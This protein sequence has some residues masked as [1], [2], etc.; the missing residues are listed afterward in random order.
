MIKNILLTA[1]RNILRHRSYSIINLIGLSVSMSIGLLVILIIQEQY[2]YDNFHPNADRI[3]RVNTMVTDKKGEAKPYASAPMPMGKALENYAFIENAVRIKKFWGTEA[4][5]ESVT[6]PV[7]G[8]FTDPSFLEIFNFP[9]AKGDAAT[10]LNQPNGLILTQAT[11]KKIFGEKD[12]MGEVISL[13]RFGEFTVTGLLEKLP[14]HTHFDFEMLASTTALPLLEKQKKIFPSLEDWGKYYSGYAYFV[15]REGTTEEEVN[16][17]LADIAKQHGGELKYGEEGYEFYLHALSDITPGP[18]LTNNMGHGMQISV[19]IFFAILAGIVMLMACF[20][21]TNMTIALSLARAKEIGIRKINGASRWQVFLQFVGE[22]VVFALIA[23]IF[24]YLL[25]QVVRPVFLLLNFSSLDSI[26]LFE[27]PAVFGWFFLFA[28]FVGINAGIL[29]S[30]YLSAFNPLRVLMGVGTMKIY[31]RLTLRKVLMVTQFALSIVFIL[32]V[33]LIN[34]QIKFVLNADYGFNQN[35]IINIKTYNIRNTYAFAHEVS[36]LTGVSQ[37]GSVSHSLGTF[38]S[39]SDEYRRNPEDEPFSMHDTFVDAHYLDVVELPFVAGT[40]F[41]PVKAYPEKFVILNETAVS[42]FGFED[43]PSA[44]GQTVIIG[45]TLDVQVVGVVKDFHYRP[46]FEAIGPMAFRY[47]PN[48]SRTMSIKANTTDIEGLAASIETIWKKHSREERPMEWQTL[49]EEIDN[50]YE[51]SGFKSSLGIFG[52]MAFIAIILACLGM[53]GMAMYTTRTRVKEIGIRKVLGAEVLDIVLL[54]SRS[55]ILLIGVAVVIG[56]P[57]SYWVGDFLLKS[58]AY[59]V[60]FT[61]GML[62]MGVGSLVLLAVFI[63][64][65]QTVAAAMKNPVKSLKV[66]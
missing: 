20:N 32:V 65:T 45:D 26:H 44:I 57:L 51:K 4:T 11:A 61:P 39:Q 49:E 34:S 56:I 63:L 64:C 35:N 25:L 54:L 7:S 9:L 52:A 24:S 29:P 36:T 55:F 50:V 41:R 62:L 1:F 12:P 53:L 33:L 60:S 15:L 66:E 22:S 37:V 21:Y 48:G 8:F 6:V 2:A 23:L 43:A 38:A 46:L 13:E 47:Y 19:L 31:S 10:A 16:A 40:N 5:F 3:Y 42:R 14:G 30:F 58:Y 27:A 59:R 28:L 18:V 17:A